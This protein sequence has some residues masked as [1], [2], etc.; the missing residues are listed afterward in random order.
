MK[1]LG[2]IL[3]L[4][5]GERRIGVAVSD[6]LQIVARPLSVIRRAARTQDFARIGHLVREQEAVRLVCGYPLSLD[7]SE[8]PQGRRV[9]RYAESLEQAV[10]V[11]VVLWNESYSTVEAEDVMQMTQPRLTPRER[12]EWV[13]AVAA[14]VILQSYLDAAS[15]AGARP[16]QDKLDS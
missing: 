5:V 7:G 1:A 11:R 13:D 10:Q 3:A 2:R 6:P 4:D 15:Q 14:A 9:R 8:G 16:S 12:R